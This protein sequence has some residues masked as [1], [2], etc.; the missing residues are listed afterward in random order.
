MS[1][2]LDTHRSPYAAFSGPNLGYVME[3]YEMFRLSPE[4]VDAELAEMFS[5]FG[6]PEMDNGEQAA[7]VGAVAPSE[8]GKVL[9]AYRLLD[10]IR[11]YGHLAADIYPLNDRPKDST[12]L[13]LA[14]YGLTESDLQAMPATLFFKNAPVGVDNGLSAVNYLR[15]LYTGKIA[16]EFAHIIDEEERNWIQSKVENGKISANLSSDDKKDLL[17]RLTK[18]EGF[19]KYIHRTFVGAKRFSIEGLDTL[20]VFLDELIRRSEEEKT[21]KVLIGMAHRGRLNVLTHILNKPYEM[22]FAQFANVSDEPF[23][24]TDGSIETSRGWFGDVKYHMGATYNAESGTKR[25]L[26]YNP[27]HLEVVNAVVTGQTRACSRAD[28]QSGSS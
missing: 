22:M 11:T 23:L 7:A 26:A 17:E 28:K 12:R 16:Y 19:E 5:K 15:T 27:S 13:E 2:S 21:K 8:F 3:M 9:S 20:V 14:Y 10:A 25:F 24:P 6:A 18:I 1:K 4:L